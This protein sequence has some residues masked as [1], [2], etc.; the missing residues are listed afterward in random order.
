MPE[1]QKDFFI[2]YN[3]ADIHWAEWIAWQ[4]E[5][6]GY[7]TILQ[8]WDFKAGSNFVLEMHRATQSV[9]RTIAILSPNYLSS[10]FTAPEWAAVFAKDSMG[11]NRLLLPI[12]VQECQPEGLLRQ[13][14][15]IDLVGLDERNARE[16]LLADIRSE[17][18]KPLSPPAFP[19]NVQHS[20]KKKPVFPGDQL[21]P[22]D[23]LYPNDS[24]LT[25]NQVLKSI[26][27]KEVPR[28]RW[29]DL[30]I[31]I[32]TSVLL[33]SIIL[34]GIIWF[35]SSTQSNS[36]QPYYYS[37]KGEL[38]NF[39][40]AI[41]HHDYQ[42]AYDDFYSSFK[43]SLS[44]DQFE[45]SINA[46]ADKH[47]GIGNCNTRITDQIGSIVHGTITYTFGDRSTKTDTYDLL[48]DSNDQ[49]WINSWSI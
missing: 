47:D 7:S 5:E 37:P 13:I 26:E 2:S 18:G 42:S 29:I 6:E 22:D 3:K 49:W 30:V 12:R 33:A 40:F 28:K 38:D 41:M 46:I 16:K 14:V 32:G 24:P 10:V 21:F 45:K 34:L 25:S 31:I 9:K 19:I 11:E 36:S 20:L 23:Q 39:C 17:R 8:A 4:L 44:M 48:Q 27:R 35:T 43:S 1:T 15:Y